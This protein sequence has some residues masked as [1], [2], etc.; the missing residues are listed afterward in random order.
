VR[1]YWI[2][3]D[4]VEADEVRLSGDVLHHI[5][6]V[7]RMHLGSKFEVIVDGGRALL[8][9][10]TAETKHESRARII[11]ERMISELPR[12]H[13]HLVMAVPRFPIFEAVVEK[14]VELGVMSIQPLF[15]DFSFIRK[16]ENVFDK[17]RARFE[18]IVVSATQQSG[19][20]DLMKI[21]EPQGIDDFLL[22]F[23]RAEGRAGLFAYEGVGVLTAKEAVAQ[24][25]QVSSVG[26]SRSDVW[27]FVGAEGGFS[28]REVQ[29]FQTVGLK[30]V[31]LGPQVLRVETACVALVSIIKYAFDLMR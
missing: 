16:Q 15:S 14:A 11:E 5:R 28:E 26:S 27:I 19:R 13:L 4:A 20:G 29:L 6:D 3:K 25:A 8:V 12:P 31:T 1:R 9:E 7:C 18:K 24:L 17:K 21:E 2:P 22:N 23:N 30:P 10:I